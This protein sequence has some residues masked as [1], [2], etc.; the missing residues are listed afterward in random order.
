[1]KNSSLLSV[2]FDGIVSISIES[3][4][5]I[6]AFNGEIKELTSTYKIGKFIENWNGYRKHVQTSVKFVNINYKLALNHT[7]KNRENANKY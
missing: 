6:L 5:V 1:M 3:Y 2:H 4:T 7:K